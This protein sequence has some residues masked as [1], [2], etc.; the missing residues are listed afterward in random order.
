MTLLIPAFFGLYLHL[1]SLRST[2]IRY[3]ALALCIAL[4]LPL[5]LQ[6]KDAKL[7][8]GF[9]EGKQRW[10]ECHLRTGRIDHCVRVSGLTIY[11][12]PQEIKER[13]AYLKQ[14][15]LNLFADQ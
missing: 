1:L 5:P 2:P 10:K 12:A 6:S 13:L 9:T 14:H 7:M 8:Q 15:H 3:V 4:L 11:P